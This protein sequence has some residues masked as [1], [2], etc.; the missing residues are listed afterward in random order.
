MYLTKIKFKI[1]QP[2]QQL[3]SCNISQLKTSF[4]R[5]VISY[6]TIHKLP[7]VIIHRNSDI[8]IHAGPLLATVTVVAV[9]ANFY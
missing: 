5:R 7:K 2:L 9:V 3:N 8:I 1:I 4:R 6:Y